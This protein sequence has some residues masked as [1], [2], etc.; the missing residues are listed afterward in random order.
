MCLS[1]T[2]ISKEHQATSFLK[3]YCAVCSHDY[4]K[5]LFVKSGDSVEIQFFPAY[6]DDTSLGIYHQ[7]LRLWILRIAKLL[8]SIVFK[9]QG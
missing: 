2:W 5:I 9:V 1:F 8:K 4:E 6:V 7:C 3:F